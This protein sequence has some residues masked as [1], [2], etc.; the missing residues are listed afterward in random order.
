MNRILDRHA[1]SAAIWIYRHYS[2]VARSAV[3]EWGG[4]QASVVTAIASGD[5]DVVQWRAEGLAAE[6]VELIRHALDARSALSD[7]DGAMLMW[8]LRNSFYFQLGLAERDSVH[9]VRYEE[10]VV[11]PAARFSKLFT[12]VGCEYNPVFTSKVYTTSVSTSPIDNPI[13]LVQEACEE[14]LGK[15]DAAAARGAFQ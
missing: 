15:L 1:G 8:W 6:S 14:L 3:K 5:A 7:L 9:P 10:L 2:D 4:H 11:Q 12:R 13:P